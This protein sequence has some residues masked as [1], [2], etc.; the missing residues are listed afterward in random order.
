MEWCSPRGSR[1]ETGAA[2]ATVSLVAS[3]KG[4]HKQKGQPCGAAC[5]LLSGTLLSLTSEGAEFKPSP[6]AAHISHSPQ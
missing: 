5:T 1:A 3:I 2:R 6:P 4:T